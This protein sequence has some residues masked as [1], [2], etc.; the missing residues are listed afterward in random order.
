VT[1]H[2]RLDFDGVE[3]LSGVDSNDATNHFWNDNHV[4]EMGLDGVWLL[5]WLG[6]LLSLT[7]LLDQTHR[8]ALE[9]TVEPTASAGV[10][11]ITELIGGEVEELFEVDTAVRKLAECSLFLDLGGLLSVVFVVSHVV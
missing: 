10:D 8:H 4:T 6:V 3:F 5:V 9:T 2:L 1:N 7:E 11:N